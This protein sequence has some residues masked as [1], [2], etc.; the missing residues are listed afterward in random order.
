MRVAE[1]EP[2]S[3]KSGS[4]TVLINHKQAARDDDPAVTCN[5]PEDK[6]VGKVVATTRTVF[7]GR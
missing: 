4:E 5:D 7:V 3:V 6:A 1:G 2:I